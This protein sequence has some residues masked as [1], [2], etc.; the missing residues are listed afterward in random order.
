MKTFSRIEIGRTLRFNECVCT[1]YNADFD[2]DE[3]N[4][5]L[6]QTLHAKS[7]A[8]Y[9]MGVKAN[10]VT[11]KNGEPVMGATQDFLTSSFLL[12][13]RDTFLTRD[14]F[15]QICADFT[16]GLECVSLPPPSVIKPKE[17]W[18]GKQVF[19]VILRPNKE[20]KNVL[21]NLEMAERWKNYTRNEWGRCEEITL[22]TS[23]E[24]VK[25]T[26]ETSGKDHQLLLQ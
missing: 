8:K 16:L 18:T 3:M 25:T 20:C 9:L 12:T 19:G 10:I 4:I 2:G 17:L 24:D 1:P 23:G 22:Q 26:L 13:Q 7:E 15:C 6:P 5:H 11:P 14:Q 21:V